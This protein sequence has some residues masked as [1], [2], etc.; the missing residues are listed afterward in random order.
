LVAF[1]LSTNVAVSFVLILLLGMC[2][3]T[4]A[5]FNDT[6]VQ[7]NV[8]NA[9]RG[10]VMSVYT[11]LWGLTPIGGLQVGLLSR[12]IGVQWA[13][14]INGVII[15]GYMLFLWFRTPVRHID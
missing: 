9:Y 14:A 13:L 4:Y 7:L 15:F 1:A 2:T 11:M 12:S 3:A 6:L 8:D 10:R 5:T